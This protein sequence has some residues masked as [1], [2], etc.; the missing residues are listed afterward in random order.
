MWHFGELHKHCETV[1]IDTLIW[2][3]LHTCADVLRPYQM[4]NPCCNISNIE[5]LSGEMFGR[6][7]RHIFCKLNPPPVLFM[8]TSI[9]GHCHLCCP[10]L[11]EQ[12][13]HEHHHAGDWAYPLVITTWAWAADSWCMGCWCLVHGFLVGLPMLWGSL[14][15]YDTANACNI[16]T[17]RCRILADRC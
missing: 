11:S 9:Q 1:G 3:T 2:A 13:M 6:Q 16:M 7:K 5:R 10:W 17:D 14:Y 4:R 8:Q 12:P 15:N